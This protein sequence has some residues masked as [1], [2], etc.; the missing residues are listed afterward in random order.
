MR[1]ATRPPHDRR[2][3]RSAQRRLPNAGRTSFSV[4]ARRF[5]PVS[6]PLVDLV[7]GAGWL[8]SNELVFGPRIGDRSVDVAIL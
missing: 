2:L 7:I 1:R 5:I 4:F 8:T 6:V 3:G